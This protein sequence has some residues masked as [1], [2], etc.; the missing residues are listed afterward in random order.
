MGLGLGLE[1]AWPAQALGSAERS[2][3]GPAGA[4]PRTGAG[5]TGRSSR[6]ASSRRCSWIERSCSTGSA[7]GGGARAMRRC[8]AG[9]VSW[10]IS[11]K[12]QIAA[13]PIQASGDG[14]SH[15]RHQRTGPP[16]TST[17][18]TL[19]PLPVPLLP[20]GGEGW[21]E[22][23]VREKFRGRFPVPAAVASR[24]RP[25][26]LASRPGRRA[27]TPAVAGRAEAAAR[28]I[29]SR[30]SEG[31]ARSGCCRSCCSNGSGFIGFL[32][33]GDAAG[34]GVCLNHIDSGWPLC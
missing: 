28:T 30:R 1:A 5:W 21:G 10:T 20:I 34:R 17:S 31:S 9:G 13:S 15:W 16:S 12:T 19:S 14:Q 33:R 24:P 22:G 32:R 7:A 26:H 2:L 3:R 29:C 4:G 27:A 23:E 8:R 11:S 6:R 18:F 25:S